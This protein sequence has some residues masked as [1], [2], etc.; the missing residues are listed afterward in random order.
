MNPYHFTV[1]VPT[2]KYTVSGVSTKLNDNPP[3]AEIINLEETPSS[4]NSNQV[5]VKI[6]DD[7]YPHPPSRGSS[8]HTSNMDMQD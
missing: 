8:I 1:P 5:R 4:K 2:L 7:P 3:D 6:S